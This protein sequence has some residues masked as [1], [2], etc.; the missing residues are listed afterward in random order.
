MGIIMV[1]TG[2]FTLLM[3]LVAF[4]I[5]LSTQN[6]FQDVASS[7]ALVGAGMAQ[8]FAGIRYIKRQREVDKQN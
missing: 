6:I 5:G 3:F 4:I 1:I 7:L 8:L 2:S